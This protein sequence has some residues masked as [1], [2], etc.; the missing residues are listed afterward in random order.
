MGTALHGRDQVNVAFG[1]QL[2]AFRQPEQRPVHRFRFGGEVADKRFFRQRR[3]A[4]YRFAQVVVQTILVAPALLGVIHIVFK[5][6]LNAR[7]EHRFRFQQM[8]QAGDGETRAVEEGFIRP[9]VNAGAG[10]ALTA[11]A[12]HFQILHL[13]AILEGDA[14]DLAVAFDGYFHTA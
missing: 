6:N 2:A 10:I 13:V 5:D 7:A 12:D 1:Q 3:Q 11:G 14:V 9:E 8:H 4:I